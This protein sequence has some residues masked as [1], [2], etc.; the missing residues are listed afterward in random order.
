MIISLEDLNQYDESSCVWYACYGSN[1][2]YERFMK[3][4][5]GD[6][7]YNSSSG[8]KDKSAPKEARQYIFPYPIYFAGKSNTWG[9]GVAF[10]DYKTTGKSYGK[11]YQITM[12]QFKDILKQEQINSCYDTILFIDT[13]DEY[14]VL[15]FTAKNKLIDM[16]NDPSEEYI[17]VIEKGLLDLYPDFDVNEIR[18]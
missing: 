12:G 7:K 16:L 13:V 10:L 9:G 8:C 14:P 1:I 11:I 17:D 4:I 15:T 6:E 18:I 3:Y 2:N 5:K